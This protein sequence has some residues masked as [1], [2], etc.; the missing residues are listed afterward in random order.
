MDLHSNGNFMAFK[1]T[2]KRVSQEDTQ[3][4][5]LQIFVPKSNEPLVRFRNTA[6]ILRGQGKWTV[7]LPVAALAYMLM[8]AGL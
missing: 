1:K 3:C 4:L 5:T 8:Q 7:N 6:Q 2:K